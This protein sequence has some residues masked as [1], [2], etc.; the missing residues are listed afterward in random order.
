MKQ[1]NLFILIALLLAMGTSCN[2]DDDDNKEVFSSLS[3]EDNK[4]NIEDD[5]IEMLDELK[6]MESSKSVET[7]TSMIHFFGLSDPFGG[8]SETKSVKIL[9]YLKPIVAVSNVSEVG[10]KT[11]FKSLTSIQEDPESLQ[12]LFDEYA[13]IYTWNFDT[14]AWDYT[15]NSTMIQF[16]FPAM[17]YGTSNNASLTISDFES[18]TGNIDY[19][20]EEDY[21]GDLPENLKVVLAE[22]NTAILTYLFSASYDNTGVPTDVETSLEFEGFKFSV[23]ASNDNNKNADFTAEFTHNNDILIK[24]SL[25]VSGDWNSDNIND[26]YVVTFDTVYETIWNPETGEYEE[27]DVIWYINEYEEFN[28]QNVFKEANA[29]FQVMNTKIVGDVKIKE[30][31]EADEEIYANDDQEGF[32][33]NAAAVLMAEAINNNANLKVQY[34]DNDEIIAVAEAY[35]YEKQDVE[36][37]WNEETGEYEEV[38]VTCTDIDIRF[39]FAD[40]STVDAETYFEEGFDDLISAFEDWLESLDDKFDF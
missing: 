10:T 7:S 8:S 27:T 26:N 32:D 16:L 11:V 12:E 22:D 33:D 23:S 38:Q 39:K 9:N 13:G 34:A 15:E 2:K 1:I 36:W 5:G 35:T 18:Y 17:E 6:L 37:E 14:Q 3:V 24:T 30:L 40:G 21:N 28:G 4:K 19:I 29:L 25:G 31:V 20:D